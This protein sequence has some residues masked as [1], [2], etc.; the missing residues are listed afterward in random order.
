MEKV[1][2][3]FE[4]TELRGVCERHAVGVVGKYYSRPVEESI[5]FVCLQRASALD[6]RACQMTM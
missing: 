2:L 6:Y 4:P 1:W 3:N 5:E